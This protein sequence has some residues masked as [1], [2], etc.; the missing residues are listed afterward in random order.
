MKRVLAI[1]RHLSFKPFNVFEWLASFRRALEQSLENDDRLIELAEIGEKNMSEALDILKQNSTDLGII[2]DSLGQTLPGLSNDMDTLISMI[3]ENQD[4]D[5]ILEQAKAIG[6]TT[7]QLK[8]IAEK[9][10]EQDARYP[11]Q[12]TTG[13]STGEDTTTGSTGEDTI[14][15]GTGEDTNVGS[16]V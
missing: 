16:T 11:G 4:R 13:G 14:D 7:S 12:D 9:F 6:S 1:L 8:E 10:Q 2:R 15:N 5:A 3:Q